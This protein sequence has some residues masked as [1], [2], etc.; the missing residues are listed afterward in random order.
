[1]YNTIIVQ[2]L[3]SNFWV[4]FRG[5]EDTRTNTPKHKNLGQ[6]TPPTR[7]GNVKILN[8]I[9]IANSPNRKSKY[10]YLFQINSRL[11]PKYYRLQLNF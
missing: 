3:F 5:F 7:Y 1:M 8:A 10:K 2:L 4:I 11:T 9:D 6:D